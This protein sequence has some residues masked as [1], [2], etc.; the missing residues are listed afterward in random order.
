[1]PFLY[2][3][4]AFAR[5]KDTEASIVI[6]AAYPASSLQV[7]D[8]ITKKPIADA[9]VE[10]N[11]TV[12]KTDSTGIVVLEVPDGVYT[13]KI[14][15]PAYLPKTLKVTVPLAAPQTVELWPLWS[16]GLGIAAGA[17]ILTALIAKAV[18]K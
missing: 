18:R 9:K 7:I 17:T 2:E 8:A 10:I 15:H 5:V 12:K 14:S 6:I 4:Y 11:T 1:M 3:S 13:V 16:I